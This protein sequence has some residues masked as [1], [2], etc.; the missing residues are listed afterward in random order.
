MGE[1]YSLWDVY[2]HADFITYP[3]LYEGFGNAFLEAI[4]YRKPIVVNTYSIYMMDIQ[5]KG[6]D[7]IELDGYVTEEAVVK[8]RAILEK[9][10]MCEAMVEK[11][12]KIATRY[13]DY[14]ELRRKLRPL[15]HE[16]LPCNR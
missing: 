13:Y 7:V 14:S 15:I 2:P 4:Y 3:S 11:N 5:P 12:Y 8:T 1:G 6:F 9:S 16:S 10:E